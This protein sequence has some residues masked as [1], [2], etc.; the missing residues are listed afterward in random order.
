MCSRAKDTLCPRGRIYE[1]ELPLSVGR[2]KQSETR[3]KRMFL[4]LATL[5][6]KQKPPPASTGT[7]LTERFGR[8]KD[9]EGIVRR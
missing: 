3:K 1:T 6:S 9:R 4:G 7:Q 2:G 5:V 8:R